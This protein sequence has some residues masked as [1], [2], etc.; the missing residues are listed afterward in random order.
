ML[1]LVVG[2]DSP[3]APATTLWFSVPAVGVLV[4]P[5]FVR[6]CFPFAAPAADWLIAMIDSD[7]QAVLVA[8]D[9]DCPAVDAE[10]TPHRG[11]SSAETSRGVLARV[12]SS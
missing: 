2:R 5:L 1:E 10:K 6:R 4:L 12:P 9:V 11:A 8:P 7:E 3:G